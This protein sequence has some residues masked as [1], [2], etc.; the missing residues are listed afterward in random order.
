MAYIAL[1]LNAFILDHSSFQLVLPVCLDN[2]LPFHSV[3]FQKYEY[4]L[5]SVHQHNQALCISQSYTEKGPLSFK[6]S[7]SK[8]LIVLIK[9]ILLI[10][11]LS[12]QAYVNSYACEYTRK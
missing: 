9:R 1:G 11:L 10:W 12:N 4:N 2:F 6:Y 5:P 8:Y 3:T 7:R